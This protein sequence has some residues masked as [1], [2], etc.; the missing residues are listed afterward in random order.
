[1]KL[2]Q[3]QQ[4]VALQ[5]YGTFSRAAQVM[6]ISQPSLSVSIREL[7]EELGAELV[8]RG[9]RGVLFTPMG[10]AVLDYAHRILQDVDGIY[11]MCKDKKLSGELKIAS[12]PHYC[13]SILLEVKLR[14]ERAHPELRIHL[15]ENDS[16]AILN[17]V[18]NGTLDAGLIQVCDLG[19]N[20][21][22][23]ALDAASIQFLVLFEEKMSVA[24]SDGHP[25][26]SR[27]SVAAEE[28]LDYPYGLYKNALNRWVGAM[29]ERHGRMNQ[30]FH[31]KD[32]DPLRMLLMRENAYTV[33]PYRSIPYGNMI[34]HSKMIA[35]PVDGVELTSQ[36]GLAYKRRRGNQL[37]A[38]FIEILREECVHYQ[39]NFGDDGSTG[40][41]K[42]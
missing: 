15:E 10:E 22:E 32:I 12:T 37:L 21:L 38:A 8:I 4:L 42:I 24:V 36:I 17:Q 35:L 16:T 19:E 3:L 40:S 31:V 29:L 33:I 1:M 23:N 34:Y 25:L 14:M 39:T 28:L 13:T 41:S 2:I 27:A 30:V 6:Y 18:E 5:E 20:I 7:E 9:N 26:A 11:Q